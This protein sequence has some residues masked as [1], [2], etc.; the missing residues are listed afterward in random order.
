MNK[1]T[2]NLNLEDRGFQTGGLRAK[3]PSNLIEN[4]K[5][6]D[7]LNR[8][9]NRNKFKIK[10]LRLH[11]CTVNDYRDCFHTIFFYGKKSSKIPKDFLKNS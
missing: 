9:H 3:Y 7:S 1:L 11:K 6:V 4:L 8:K 2:R 10:Q 5:T